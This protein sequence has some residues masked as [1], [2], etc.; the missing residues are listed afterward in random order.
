MG[1]FTCD[2]GCLPQG[3]ADPKMRAPRLGFEDF[4]GA[5]VSVHELGHHGEADSGALDVTAL[6]CF[7]LIKRFENSVAL[8]G[9]NTWSAVHDVQDQLVGLAASV[10]RDRTAPWG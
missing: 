7:A 9:G 2:S 6:R 1:C 10:H 5:A 8:L 3:Q 4:D